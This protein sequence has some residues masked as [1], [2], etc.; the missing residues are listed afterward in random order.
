M[1]VWGWGYYSM[2][3]AEKQLTIG[4]VQRD[5]SWLADLEQCG[6]LKIPVIGCDGHCLK[7]Q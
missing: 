3:L 4:E 2:C 6:T 1:M 5:F 7:I